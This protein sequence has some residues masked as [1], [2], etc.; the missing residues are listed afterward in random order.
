MTDEPTIRDGD[1]EEDVVAIPAAVDLTLLDPAREGARFDA[2]ALSIANEAFAARAARAGGLA[3]AAGQPL[4]SRRDT[5][6]LA[7]MVAWSRPALIAASLILAVAIA[8]L[9]AVPAPAGAAPTSLA[10]SAGIPATLVEWSTTTRKPNA[11]E[12]VDTFNSLTA[13]GAP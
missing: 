1:D 7:L 4:R 10:E 11:A 13:R 8:T 5:G 12:L 6:T 3:A 9:V 2:L